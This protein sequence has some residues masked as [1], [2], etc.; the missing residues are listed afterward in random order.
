[1]KTNVSKGFT[2]IKL[3]VVIA[4]IA[5]LLSVIVP[6][7]RKAKDYAKQLVCLNNCKTFGM[8]N[9]M[10]ANAYNG[11]L[12]PYADKTRIVNGRPT[13]WCSNETFL[14]YIALSNYDTISGLSTGEWE[15][16][17]KYHCPSAKVRPRNDPFWITAGWVIRTTYGF[18]AYDSAKVNECLSKL[19]LFAWRSTSI[20]QPA[21]KIIF[22]DSSDLIVTELRANYKN[23][24][25]IYGDEYRN[26]LNRADAIEITSYRHNEKAN[27]TFADGH[28]DTLKKENAFF[29]NSS[30][31][32][33]NAMNDHLWLVHSFWF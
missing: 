16:P 6:A 24:W 32:P 7:L 2:L 15:L 14:N 8:A 17:D 22:A 23:Y 27:F 29:Y 31:L 11:Y 5:L 1:M 10:Y 21:E 9:V 13:T 20:K 30:G 3:L 33:D 18:N 25:D 19:P 26:P 4:I 12:V 28:A